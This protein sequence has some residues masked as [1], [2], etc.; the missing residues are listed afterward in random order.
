MSRTVSTRFL[1]SSFLDHACVDDLEVELQKTISSFVGD[2]I[3]L[4][5]SMDGPN[6]NWKVLRV[7]QEKVSVLGYKMLEM[8]YCGL[9]TIHGAFKAGAATSDFG[10]IRF[11]RAC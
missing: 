3:F 9:H 8:G 6:V 1:T 5:V 10:V 11:L 7:M 4:Q 2:S